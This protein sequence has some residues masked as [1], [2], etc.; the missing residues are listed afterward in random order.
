MSL[1]EMWP[2]LDGPEYSDNTWL[3]V[4]KVSTVVP[5]TYAAIDEGLYDDPD[6]FDGET[7]WDR[8]PFL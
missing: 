4:H 8:W 1:I 6:I 3:A 2:D 7:A 5:V